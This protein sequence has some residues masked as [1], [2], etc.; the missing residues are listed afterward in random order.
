MNTNNINYINDDNKNIKYDKTVYKLDDFDFK[1]N[2]TYTLLSARRS[3]KSFMIKNLVY[4]LLKRKLIDMIYVVSYTASLDE[5]YTSWV[6]S[7]LVIHPSKM[8]QTIELIMKVQKSLGEKAKKV[9]FIMDDFD[10]TSSNDSI[11]SLYTLGRHF[12][13]T[14]ILSA[15]ITTKGVSTSIRNNT[16]YLFVRKLNSKTIKDNVFNMLLNTNFDNGNELYEYV[17]NNTEDYQFILYLNDDR[18]ADDSIKLVKAT[19]KKF[20]FTYTPPPKENKKLL[21]NN[22]KK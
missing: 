7:S 8:A 15:Q 1:A 14:T 4:L 5:A 2:A 17:K 6:P 3:G 19:P 12:N 10:L 22:I 18:P 21:V 16:Q 20:K 13:I 11:N 9:C